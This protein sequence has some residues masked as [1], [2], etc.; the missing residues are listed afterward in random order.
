LKESEGGAAIGSERVIRVSAAHTL[1]YPS[2]KIEITY[3]KRVQQN[4]A[5]ICDYNS[6]ELQNR[7]NVY[8]N[9]GASLDFTIVRETAQQQR[10]PKRWLLLTKW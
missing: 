6:F 1:L 10:H 8:F 2:G 9:Y 7:S 3:Y 5:I 4:L